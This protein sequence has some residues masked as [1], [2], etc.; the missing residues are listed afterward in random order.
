MSP[1]VGVKKAGDVV[2]SEHRCAVIHGMDVREGTAETHPQFRGMGCS[3]ACGWKEVTA[4]P[5]DRIP[6]EMVGADARSVDSMTML[7]VVWVV[8]L[9]DDEVL[10][11]GSARF[12]ST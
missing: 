2:E 7:L 4:V 12:T 5:W 3:V 9:L 6:C 8:L 10:S 11:R 1:D